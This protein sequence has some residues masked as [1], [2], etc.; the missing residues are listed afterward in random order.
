MK[1]DIEKKRKKF[2]HF[3]TTLCTIIVSYFNFTRPILV[4][5]S[6]WSQCLNDCVD[7][8]VL[9]FDYLIE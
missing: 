7:N 5:V 4:L 1:N 8:V 2:S 3:Y 9:N 6:K